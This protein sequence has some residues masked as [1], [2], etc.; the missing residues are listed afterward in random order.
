M[1]LGFGFACVQQGAG[2]GCGVAPLVGYDAAPDGI[3]PYLGEDL[4]GALGAGGDVAAVEA[5]DK[6]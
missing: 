5:F 4:D 1:G 3:V 2:G 6:F